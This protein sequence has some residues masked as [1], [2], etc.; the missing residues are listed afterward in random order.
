MHYLFLLLA[1]LTGIGVS[2]QA[3]VNASLRHVL[4]N[5]VLAAAVSFGSGFVTL[6]LMLLVSQTTLP[7]AEA[8]RQV[9]WWKWT[10]GLIGA[11]YVTTVIISVPKIGAA[12]LLSLSVA[13]QLI[14]AILLDHYGLIGFSIHPANVWRW[15]GV[16]LILIGVWLVV[17]N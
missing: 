12:N 1:F 17:R 8:I 14:A 6:I 16:V 7:T 3:G 2:V 15:L 4:A 9:S 5:P 13:G 11:V 10:G